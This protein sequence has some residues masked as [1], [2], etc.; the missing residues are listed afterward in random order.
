MHN[1]VLYVFFVLVGS[2]FSRTTLT[3]ILCFISEVLNWYTSNDVN[4]G[5]IR[6]FLMCHFNA[7]VA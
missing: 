4:S 1:A 2:G 3:L 6:A 5:F 7:A